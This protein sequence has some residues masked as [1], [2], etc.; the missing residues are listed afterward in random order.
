M[1]GGKILFGPSF[2]EKWGFYYGGF[3]DIEGIRSG[4]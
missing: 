3:N 4:Q 1:N 2:D